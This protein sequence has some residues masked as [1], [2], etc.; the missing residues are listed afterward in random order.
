MS[1]ATLINPAI[2]SSPSRRFSIPLT[3]PNSHFVKAP[4][5][6]RCVRKNGEING[7]SRTPPP[8]DNGGEDDA[9]TSLEESSNVELESKNNEIWRLFK[10]AQQNILYLNKQRVKAVDE[11]NKAK[12]EKQLLLN[13]IEQLE[14]ENKRVSG[15]DNLVVCWELLLRIDSM[16]LGGMVSTEEASKLRRM[17]IDSKV[18]LVDVFSGLLQ[19]RDA[20]LLAELR[21]FSEGSKRKGYHVIHI[22]TEMEPLISVGPLAPYIT[23]L[24]RALQRKG[25]LVEVILPKYASLD[26]DEVQGLREIEADSYSF[27]NGQ[28]HGNR[29]WTGVVRGIGVTFI[30]PLYFSSF[31]NRDGIYDHPDDFE[32]FTYFS[33]ASLDYIAKSGKQPDVLHLHNWETAIVGPLFW[34]IFAKQGLGNTRILLTCQGFDSQCLD[35][36]DKLALCGLDPGRLHRPDRFQDTAK[37]HL[38]NILKG[39]VVYSNKVIVMSSMHSKGRIIHSMSHGL[40]PTLTMH[41]EKLLVAPY[42]FDNSTWDPSTDKFLP[43]NYST[44][45]MRG[46]YACKVALQQQAGISTHASS[47]LVGCIISEES[48]FDLEKLKAVVR[49]AIR[50]GAQFVLLGNGSV[51]T[52]YRALRSFQEAVEDSNVKFFYNYDEALSHL[53]FAGSDIILCHSFHDPL[54]QVQLKALR[55]GAAPV[56]EASG[57]NHLRYSSDHDHE[58]T[59]FSQFM[60]STFGVMSLSQALDEMKNNPS[61]WKTKILNAMK[62]DFSWDS[63]C[64][65]THVSAY[66]AVKSL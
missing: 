43:V 1:M 34:D 10:E 54:L 28:L 18:S 49:N 56:S 25:H 58:I 35:E 62:K 63:E 51:S 7:L 55:Y 19:Q 38:V 23:G 9:E 48:G 21:L 53:V 16:V 45:N 3:S 50:E 5:L 27:F 37:T 65:E 52:T 26:L 64:Y 42:G 57:D 44:E 4:S 15:K 31:F 41:K 30:Q 36:P 32:R 20:E 39:G 46:K 2:P 33:R 29:I 13:K 8:M 47:I 61:T 12:R 17:V 60:R 22:C 24:S 66:T 59:K 14:K 40:E 11:L 6:L